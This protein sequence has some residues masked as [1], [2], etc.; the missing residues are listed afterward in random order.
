MSEHPADVVPN[1]VTAAYYRATKVAINHHRTT[2]SHGSGQ[3]IRP[4]DAESLGPRAYEIAACGAF[5]LMD[6]SRAEAKDVFGDALATYTAGSS[7]SLEREV[8]WWLAHPDERQ[9]W[10]AAQHECV[11]PHSWDTR[12]R[13]VL[14]R[15]V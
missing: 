11:K 14:E 10:A 2:T 12:A 7:A 13:Q 6:D 1:T 3:H 15:L 4:E 9:L 8:R 5:Q